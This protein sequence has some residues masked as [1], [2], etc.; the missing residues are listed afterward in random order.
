MYLKKN[1]AFL[2]VVEAIALRYRF[3]AMRF[4]KTLYA[5]NRWILF[6]QHNF[7]MIIIVGFDTRNFDGN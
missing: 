2:V 1:Y 7:E 4:P 6:K 3:Y 5:D